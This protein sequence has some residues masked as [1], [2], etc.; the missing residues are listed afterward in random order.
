MEFFIYRDCD[1]LRLRKWVIELSNGSGDCLDKRRMFG[2]LFFKL[3]LRMKMTRMKNMRAKV[4]ETLLE[5]E[6]ET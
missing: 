5:E 2:G 3:R 4:L 1:T 6:W